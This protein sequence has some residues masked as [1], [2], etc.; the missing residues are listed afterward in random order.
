MSNIDVKI[1][2]TSLLAILATGVVLMAVVSA[3]LSSVD[4]N[5]AQSVW[6]MGETMLVAILLIVIITALVVLSKR[7]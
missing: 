1:I 5:A 2:A 7:R 3:G 4:T 6:G